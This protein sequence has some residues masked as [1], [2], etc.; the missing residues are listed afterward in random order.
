MCWS[1]SAISAGIDLAAFTIAKA[2]LWVSLVK[3]SIVEARIYK[4]TLAR[5]IIIVNVQ[6][7][8]VSTL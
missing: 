5:T 4:D 6:M 1:F 8:Y 3:E 2:Y 7:I